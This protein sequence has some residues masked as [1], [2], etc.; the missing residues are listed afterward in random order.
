ME[1]L[2]WTEFVDSKFLS[3]Y[4]VEKPFKVTLERVA[5]EKVT[6]PK[7]GKTEDKI[8]L[9]WKGAKKGQILTKRVAKVLA[10]MNGMKKDVNEWVGSTVELYTTQ[11]KHFGQMH[12]ILNVRVVRN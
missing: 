7:S 2:N 8:I 3:G 6:Q 1:V 11:E 10:M 4:D 9:Y 12:P 5:K